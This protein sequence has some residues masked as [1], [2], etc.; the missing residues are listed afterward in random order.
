MKHR[1]LGS[2]DV[3]ALGL[4]CMGMSHA[5]GPASDETAAIATLRR[6]VD[7]GVTLFDT[8]EVYGP[9]ANEIL[10]GKALKPMRDKVVIATK[11]GFRIDAAKPSAEMI[12]GTDSRPENVRAVAEASLKRLGVEVIDLFYQHRVDPAV[13]IEEG[14]TVPIESALPPRMARI[15]AFAAIVVA[16]LCGGLIGYSISGLQCDSGCGTRS[17]VG[18]LI[19][20]VL[21]AGGVAVVA[22]LVLRAMSEWRVIEHT[23]DPKAARTAQRSRRL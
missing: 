14:P 13:P 15:L 22:V 23:G 17:G 8:A 21:A 10:V 5:Y 1:T 16:G 9:Y 6:A 11:F 20:A 3:S 12:A 18:A 2:L 19:G 7:L 4:G